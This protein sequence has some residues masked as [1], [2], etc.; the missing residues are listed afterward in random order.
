[1]AKPK[2]HKAKERPDGY[3]E[4][5]ENIRQINRDLLVA[6]LADI[7]DEAALALE[8]ARKHVLVA[9]ALTRPKWSA[10]NRRIEELPLSQF[11]ALN[12]RAQHKFEPLLLILERPGQSGD[13]VMPS[14]LNGRRNRRHYGCL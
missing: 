14:K 9:L 3:S 11:A 7:E 4:A 2:T 6:S 13:R 8:S 12:M 5:F 1:M 10:A